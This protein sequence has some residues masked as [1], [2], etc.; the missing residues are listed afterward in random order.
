[1]DSLQRVHYRRTTEEDRWIAPHIPEL[2]DT[3]ECHIF[4]NIVFTVSVFTYLFKYLHKGPDHTWF[5]IPNEGKD[6]ISDYVEGRYLS[7][8]EAAWR[9]LGFEITSKDPSVSCLP[10]HL[11]GGN[12]TQFDGGL[13]A[14]R[15]S[16]SLLIRYFHQPGD[17]LFATMTY[18][19]YFNKYVLYKWD[20]MST[21]QAGKHLDC[22]IVGTHAM[23][24]SPRRSGRKVCQIQTLSPTAGEAFYLRCLLMHRP[25]QSFVDARTIDGMI[26]DT[27]HEAALQLGLFRTRN[28]GYYAMFEAV[29]SFCTPTQLQFLFARVILEG[30]PA[31]PLWDEFC[32]CTHCWHKCFGCHTLQGWKNCT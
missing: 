16:T 13:D 20:A 25:A 18:T 4:V 30:Y 22:P 10:V 32:H 19:E 8:H 15:S 9:I 27:Y 1:M 31:Q 2:I 23:K 5:H 24:V 12:I 21:L 26:Y 11:P 14:S 28:E 17:A 6:E 29:S 7:A 3:L